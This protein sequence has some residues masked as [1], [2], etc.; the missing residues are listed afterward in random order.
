MVEL[1]LKEQ[2]DLA[3]Y[4][5]RQVLYVHPRDALPEDDRKALM[6]A[7]TFISDVIDDLEDE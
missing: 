7:V 1:P 6:D 4:H 3:G 2:L 5:L